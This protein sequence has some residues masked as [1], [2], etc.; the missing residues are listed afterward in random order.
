MMHLA[1]VLAKR[2]IHRKNRSF[3]YSSLLNFVDIKNTQESHSSID[4]G[5]ANLKESSQ[6]PV[7][8]L[9]LAQPAA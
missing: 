2:L 8:R 4:H 3:Y 7:F 6:Q 5:F 9:S 1:T